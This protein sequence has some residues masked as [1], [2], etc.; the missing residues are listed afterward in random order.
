[1][2][3]KSRSSQA[4][5]A[6]LN[7][8]K[9]FIAEKPCKTCGGDE[10]YSAGRGVCVNCNKIRMDKFRSTEE[11]KRKMSE[12]S[13][14]SIAKKMASSDAEKERRLNYNREYCKRWRATKHGK[15][16]Q[17]NYNKLWTERNYLNVAIRRTMRRMMLSLAA[18]NGYKDVES[19]VGYS[20]DDFISKMLET[21]P[22]MDSLVS[23][24]YHVDHIL[25]IKWFIN[26]NIIDQKI[27]NSLMNLQ[28]I[29]KSDNLS[30]SSK[31]LMKDKT[32]WE[33]CYEIQMKVYGYV[34]YKE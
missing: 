28:A 31:W 1:M 32:E 9:R 6:R 34:K 17:R 10:F 11:G 33:W 26:N 22:S 15:I 12:Y 13:K 8:E 5:N 14:K 19:V 20:G 3:Q 4:E 27:V 7:G 29:K 23:G 25:P 18:V 24:E 16:Y 21:A 30:K 2:S